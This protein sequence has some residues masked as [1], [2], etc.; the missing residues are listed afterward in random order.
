M[1]RW[2]SM[3]N[4]LSFLFKSISTAA[5]L[6]TNLSGSSGILLH[7]FSLSSWNFHPF[8]VQW[9]FAFIIS[10]CSELFHIKSQTCVSLSL[11]MFLSFLLLFTA[12]LKKQS[13]FNVFHLNLLCKLVSSLNPLK[14]FWQKHRWFLCC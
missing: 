3:Q 14:L 8:S 5:P 13:V 12:Y 11:T 10:L 9:L 7:L 1:T 6:Y 4:M 2:G